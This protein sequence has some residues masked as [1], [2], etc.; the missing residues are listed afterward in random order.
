MSLQP[1]FL[2]GLAQGGVGGIRVAGQ[3]GAYR[4][5]IENRPNLRWPIA[6]RTPG[7]STGGDLPSEIVGQSELAWEPV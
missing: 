5:A 4:D 1:D 6:S 3:I 7:L 2:V